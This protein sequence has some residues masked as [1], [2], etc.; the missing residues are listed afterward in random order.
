VKSDFGER[1]ASLAARVNQFLTFRA[2][3]RQNVIW[4]RS[5]PRIYLQSPTSARAPP[6]ALDHNTHCV[7]LARVILLRNSDG[8]DYGRHQY[9]PWPWWFAWYPIMHKGERIW[10]RWIQ[11]RWHDRRLGDGWYEYR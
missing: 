11:R 3:L 6:R 9:L 7:M 8:V 2:S 5:L 10:L 1:P 4:V